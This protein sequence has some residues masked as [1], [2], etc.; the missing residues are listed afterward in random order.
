[1]LD[2]ARQSKEKK[3]SQ[4]PQSARPSTSKSSIS[5]S[6]SASDLSLAGTSM[7]SRSG[8]AD[9]RPLTSSRLRKVL[10]DEAKNAT[11]T[12]RVSWIILQLNFI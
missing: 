8:T 7:L 3:R 6:Y 12:P 9:A 4:R 2:S 10:K 11:V 1:M 5:R